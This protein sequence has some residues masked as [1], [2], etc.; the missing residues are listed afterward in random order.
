[1]P[2]DQYSQLPGGDKQILFGELASYALEC[3]SIEGNVLLEQSIREIN[4]CTSH[5]DRSANQALLR[6][7]AGEG[8]DEKVRELLENVENLDIN[9][10][11]EEG[12]TALMLA[13]GYGHAA[14]VKLLLEY[15]NCKVNLVDKG[16]WTALMLASSNGHA[17]VVKLL[18][19]HDK[20]LV[21]CVDK[22]G[23]SALML[24]SGFGH[25]A[26]VKLLLEHG[27]CRA[28]NAVSNDGSTALWPAAD[29]NHEEIIGL[30]L[31]L[32][33]AE[34]DVTN[35][36]APAAVVTQ[37]AQEGQKQAR[38]SMNKRIALSCVSLVVCTGGAYGVLPAVG[39]GITAP[40][41]MVVAGV[42]FVAT[43][44]LS[45]LFAIKNVDVH[46]G[47]DSLGGLGDGVDQVAIR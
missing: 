32:E 27:G 2:D 14:V 25:A 31:D 38:L 39:V 20:C 9:A 40:A 6:K 26:V 12:W 15:N 34:R 33:V 41:L 21:N 46:L 16:G 28:K 22:G 13:S 24:A 7:Y 45:G 5:Y 4:V 37:S 35:S 23:F 10:A 43:W 19:E 36:S 29:N 42:S 47:A 1:V 44:L 8:N 3:R 17:A 30:L 18:L 11:S